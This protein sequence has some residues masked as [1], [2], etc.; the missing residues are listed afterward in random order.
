VSV[1]R[2]G[3]IGGSIAGCGIATSLL[4]AGPEVTIFERSTEALCDRG[5]SIVVPVS[6][7]VY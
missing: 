7:I 3:I 5:A 1:K 6:L 4:R 2:I